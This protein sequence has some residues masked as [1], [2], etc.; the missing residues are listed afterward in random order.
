[1]QKFIYLIYIT[2][3]YRISSRDIQNHIFREVWINKFKLL[4]DNSE[5]EVVKYGEIKW[6]GEIG[7][8]QAAKSDKFN[9]YIR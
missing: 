9:S 8:I 5:N 1:M 4:F 2:Y 7:K 3:K 6:L